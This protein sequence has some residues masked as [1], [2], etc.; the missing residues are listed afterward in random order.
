MGDSFTLGRVSGVKIGVNWSVLVIFALIGY[1]LSAG[2]FPDAYP[3]YGTPSYVTAGLATALVFFGSLL[4]HELAHAIVARRNGLEVEGITLWLFGG[5]A[6]LGGEARDP[7]AELRIAGVGPLVSVL[8]GAG[9]LLLAWL[10]DVV[11]YQGL[12]VG[13]FAWLGAINLALAVF[14]VVPAAPLDGGRL[15]R[16][17]VWWR[18]GDRLRA[19][20]VATR[21]GQVF[22]WVLVG[23]G[24]LAFLGAGNVGGLWLAL[25]GWFLISAA[26]VEGQQATVRGR[27]GGLAVREVMTR[28]PKTAPGSMTVADFLDGEYFRY[29]HSAFPI[30]GTDPGEPEGLVTMNRIK[31]VPPDR[32]ATTLLQDIACPLDETPQ[33]RPDE[34]VADLLPRMNQSPEMRALVIDG[35]RL[36]GIVSPSD[37]TRTLEWLSLRR[38]A[39]QPEG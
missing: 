35:G 38:S 17:I 8:L 32:R 3:G 5:V 19:T 22:G 23:G 9:F 1:G 21:A 29:R 28:D 4:A 36:L 16:S 26:S 13:G 10:V 18:T 34:P 24:L 25:I 27:L 30:T 12:V 31:Q 14:N 15:L 20:V 37:V 7:G 39:G 2:R 6:R 11:G 33:A